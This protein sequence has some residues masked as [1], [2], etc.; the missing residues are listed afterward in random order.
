MSAVLATFWAEAKPIIGFRRDLNSVI[1]RVPVSVTMRCEVAIREISLIAMSEFPRILRTRRSIGVSQA[2]LPPETYSQ[3][4][5]LAAVQSLTVSN[6]TALIR[7]AMAYARKTSYGHENSIQEAYM[8]VLDGKRV[9]P[10]NVAAVP[11]LC[12]V[13]RSIAV[14]LAGGRS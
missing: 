8:R 11:F 10:K 9:W 13:M 12:G 3:A 5:I 6:K 1:V 4:E 7:V 14:G 2:E